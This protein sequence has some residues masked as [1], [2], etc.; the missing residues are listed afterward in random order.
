MNR[1]DALKSV[2]LILGTTIIG[3]D[4]FLTG[5]VNKNNTFTLSQTDLTLLNEI[6]ETIL[7]KTNTP[8]GKDA[9]VAGFMNTIV[10][11]YYSNEEQNTFEDGMTYVDDI[12]NNKFNNDFIVLTEENKNTLLMDLEAEAKAHYNAKKERHHFYIMFK[13]LTIWAYMSSEIVAKNAFIHMPL[14]E[15]YIG[16]IDYTAGDKIVYN[17]YGNS[18]GAR[19]AAMYFLNNG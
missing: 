6:G 1:R 12:S 18:A 11:D 2:G 4:A 9:D 5:C 15:K 13:Q 14:V 10:A 17:D 7:P 8:G 3:A 16:S 19:A